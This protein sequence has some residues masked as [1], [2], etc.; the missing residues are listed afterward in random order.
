MGLPTGVDLKTEPA[1]K[2]QPET[3]APVVLAPVEPKPVLVPVEAPTPAGGPA[4][5]VTAPAADTTDTPEVGGTLSHTGG[6]GS[7]WTTQVLWLWPGSG[8]QD[9][10]RTRGLWG[11]SR[12][13][14][15]S[16]PPEP[17]AGGA[18]FITLWEHL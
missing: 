1:A 10:V 5:S 16:S 18:E 15:W 11:G 14:L 4:G 13:C 12:Q 8:S 7:I 9:R 2:P 6:G 17:S 3:P